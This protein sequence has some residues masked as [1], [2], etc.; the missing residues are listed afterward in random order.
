M[1]LSSAHRSRSTGTSGTSRL[2]GTDRAD[3]LAG[4]YRPERTH[5]SDGSDWRYG[6]AGHTGATRSTRPAQGSNV[7]H[8]KDYAVFSVEVENQ[9]PDTIYIEP[10]R[11]RALTGPLGGLPIPEPLCPDPAHSGGGIPPHDSAIYTLN[12][13]LH[14][15]PLSESQLRAYRRPT[16][17]EFTATPRVGPAAV[18]RVTSQH[19]DVGGVSLSKC[20]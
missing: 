5:W 11:A 19:F 6:F 16:E 7:K 18:V 14:E 2:A 9:S 13:N 20:G 12:L 15:L 10:V 17:V 3:G 8:A 1:R 4:T